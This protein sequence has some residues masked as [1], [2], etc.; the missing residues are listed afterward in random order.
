MGIKIKSWKG[1]KMR[2]FVMMMKIE[3]LLK[4]INVRKLVIFSIQFQ[5]KVVQML[6]IDF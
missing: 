3:K 2:K 6:L 1:M 5:Y 4:I